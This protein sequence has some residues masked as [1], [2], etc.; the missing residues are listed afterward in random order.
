MDWDDLR[1]ICTPDFVAVDHRP[2]G[3]LGTLDCEQWAESLKAIDG[4]SDGVT[5]AWYDLLAWNDSA[6][7]GAVARTGTITDGGGA[8]HDEFPSV[9]RVAHGRLQRFDVFAED[10]TEGALAWL[11]GLAAPRS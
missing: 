4:L 11:E 8:I 3:V 9:V 7:V 1:T 5:Y 10:D 2:L 6:I